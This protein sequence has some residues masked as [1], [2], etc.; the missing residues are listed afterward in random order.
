MGR[1]EEGN[2]HYLWYD[3]MKGQEAHSSSLYQKWSAQDADKSKEIN[4]KGEENGESKEE[5]VEETLQTL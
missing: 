2:T 5:K 4:G 1:I 3:G